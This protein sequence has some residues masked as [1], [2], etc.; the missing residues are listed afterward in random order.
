MKATSSL[1]CYN[2]RLEL[3]NLGFQVKGMGE[4]TNSVK[5]AEKEINRREKVYK[6]IL[7]EEG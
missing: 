4:Y 5:K 6:S 7:M 3:L 2:K 1:Q